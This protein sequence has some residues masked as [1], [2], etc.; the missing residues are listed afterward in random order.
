[1]KLCQTCHS[2]SVD[3]NKHCPY[4]GQLLVTDPLASALQESL[5][6][7]YS[8]TKLIGTGSMG[9]VYR[10]QHQSLDEVAIKVMLGPPDNHKLSERF[11]REARALRKLHHQNSVLV[12]DLERSPTGLTYMVMEMVEGHSLRD[13]L[14]ERGHLSIEATME[15]AEAVCAALQAAH[16][17]G[18]IHRDLKPDNIL[19]AEEKTADG[20]VS[21]IIKIADFGIV[22]L[23]GTQQGGEEASMQLTKHG[24]PIGTPFYM[25]PEQWFGD[26]PGFTALDGRTDIYS[27]GCTLYEMLSGRPPFLGKTSDEMRRK[28][29]NDSA[30]PLNEIAPLV[31][32][33]L[34]RAI[35]RSLEKDRDL[36]PASAEEFAAELRRA[37]NES[38]PGENEVAR[39]PSGAKQE[40]EDKTPISAEQLARMQAT[41]ESV[42]HVRNWANEEAQRA[43]E[44]V[45][46]RRVPTAPPQ[47]PPHSQANNERVEKTPLQAPGSVE[48]FEATLVSGMPPAPLE[49]DREDTAPSPARE[50]EMRQTLILDRKPPHTPQSETTTA[51]NRERCE[52]MVAQAGT[53]RI[54]VLADESDGVL[55]GRTPVPL[56]H[57]PQAV[58][59]V[60]NMRGRM[61][62]VL[63][64]LALLGEERASE[65]NA[66]PAF[67]IALRGDEQLAL[68][69]T[70]LESA[71]GIYMDEITPPADDPD[72]SIIRGLIHQGNGQII[73]L[74]TRELF[75][76]ATHGAE[77]RRR[78]T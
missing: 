22:K 24:T 14:K 27:L 25:S 28:H 49:R 45:R 66:P 47:M 73:L 65:T 3:E 23:R 34:S 57:A 55:T 56:P 50:S 44:Q 16:E 29:L 10:A 53:L 17:R 13:E 74:D 51:Q 19:L 71:I 2:I 72:T 32:E 30:Q 4:D 1:M 40:S 6:A 15:I 31:P 78:R 43:I 11:L 76:A 75:D 54:G 26:G 9:A 64:P 70:H 52:L 20:Q 68:A 67:I 77:R 61:L 39:E 41:E 33:A 8:L 37:Y 7:K 35:M 21:R 58:L 60:V 59:G 12:Y 36:R 63:D 62:T 42:P 18:I 5:G 69:V 46:Q 38:R 48:D